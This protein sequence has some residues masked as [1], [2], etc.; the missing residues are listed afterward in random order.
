M[1][2]FYRRDTRNTRAFKNYLCIVVSIGYYVY[3]RGRTATPQQPRTPKPGHTAVHMFLSTKLVQ[4]VDNYKYEYH[5]P[6]RVKAVS[7]LLDTGLE[8]VKKKK[9][10]K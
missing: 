3:K 4:R 8:A 5:I 1:P 2:G 9:Q 6:T 7:M 10:S